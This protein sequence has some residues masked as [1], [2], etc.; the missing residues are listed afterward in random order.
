MQLLVEQ[1]Y[2]R[3][4][5]AHNSLKKV[6]TVFQRFDPNSCKCASSVSKLDFKLG[7]IEA[8]L[9]RIVVDYRYS[10]TNTDTRKALLS[11][12]GSI[13]SNKMDLFQQNTV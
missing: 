11:I 1:S 9:E 3:D 10:N 8:L 5:S 12:L 7:H 13:S 2:G 4:V 6:I